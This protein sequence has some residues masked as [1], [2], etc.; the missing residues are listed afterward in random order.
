MGLRFVTVMSPCGAQ[1]RLNN[2]EE[3]K[4]L[5]S[6]NLLTFPWKLGELTALV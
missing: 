4:S 2:S 3:T 6:S 5:G 1:R